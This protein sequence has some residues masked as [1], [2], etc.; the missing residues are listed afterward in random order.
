VLRVKAPYHFYTG[1][2]LGAPEEVDG[3][4]SDTRSDLRQR[5]LDESDC[6]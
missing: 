6:N 2:N 5:D 4:E 1:Y 3:W